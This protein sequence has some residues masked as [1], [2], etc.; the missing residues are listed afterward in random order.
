MSIVVSTVLAMATMLLE[1]VWDLRAT[2]GI[3][4][5]SNKVR[6]LSPVVVGTAVRLGVTVIAAEELPATDAGPAGV[7]ATLGLTFEVEGSER[8]ACVAEIVFRY[9]F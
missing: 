1:D 7:Q 9:W 6:H 3:D 4:C 8:P 5:G 2:N